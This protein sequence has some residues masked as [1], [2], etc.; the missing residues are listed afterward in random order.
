V[1]HTFRSTVADVPQPGATITLGADDGHHLIRVARR[2]VGDSTEVIDPDGQIWPAVIEAVGPPVQLR[3]GDTPRSGPAVVPI[4]LYI[5]SLEW[6]RFDLVV[7]K[8]TE[9]GIASL[10][11]FSSE[12]AGRKTD[13]Q[14]F[15]RRRERLDRL[16]DAAAK[17]SGQGRRPELRGLVPFSTVIRGIPTGTGFVVDARGQ[18]TLGQALRAAAPERAAIVVGSDAGFSEAE[19]DQARQSGLAIC[20]LGAS[21]L[22][23]ETAALVAVAVAADGLGAMGIVG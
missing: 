9:I 14:G 20:G 8:C 3:V 17:Q 4:D 18:R 1:K 6:G 15:D 16:A 10:T 11:M 5:G 7:E 21:T 12:R 22:R 2:G 13:Q 23:A 19:I